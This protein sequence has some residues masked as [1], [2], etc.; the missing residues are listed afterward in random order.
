MESLNFESSTGTNSYDRTPIIV[1]VVSSGNLEVLI[2]KS[3]ENMCTC[4][5]VTSEAGYGNIWKSVIQ[6][7]FDKYQLTNI[8]IFIND[9][10]AS[11]SVASLRLEQAIEKFKGNI[12]D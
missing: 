10:G 9:S 4:K 6:D 1:G 11:P 7:F 8:N 2:E 12:N 3:D 5:I